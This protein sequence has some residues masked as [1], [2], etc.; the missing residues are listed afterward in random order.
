M[1]SECFNFGGYDSRTRVETVSTELLARFSAEKPWLVVGGW[2]LLL[3]VA[4]SLMVT[5]LADGLTTA[6]VFVNTP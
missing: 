1:I 4:I 6:F 3:A 5:M 2:V